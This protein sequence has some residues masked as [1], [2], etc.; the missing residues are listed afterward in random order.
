MAEG[1]PWWSG[2][3]NDSS[4]APAPDNSSP[5]WG[6]YGKAV[7]SGA[8]ELG[9]SI[10]AGIQ[11]Y[12][13]DETP[14]GR[15]VKEMG[16]V[17][18]R[19]LGDQAEDTSQSMTPVARQRLEA[20]ITSPEFWNHPLSSTALKATKMSPAA[21]AMI[22]PG[23]LIADATAATIATAGVGG[24]LN[25]AQLVDNV[26]KMVDQLPDD[27]LRAKSDYYN[28]LRDSN[29]SEEDARQ[30]LKSRLVTDAKPALNFAVGSVAAALGP[31]AAIVRGAKGAT[32]VIGAGERGALGRAAIGAGEA[33][34]GMGTQ[35]GVEE[36]SRQ[37]AAIQEG[38]Q[39]NFDTDK[40][41]EAVLEPTYLGAITGGAAGA[42]IKGKGVKTEP[43]PKVETET[44]TTSPAAE[45]RG[46]T[47]EKVGTSQVQKGTGTGNQPPPPDAKRPDVRYPKPSASDEEKIRSATLE[48]VLARTRQNKGAEVV[49]V[50]GPTS[51]QELALGKTERLAN[52]DVNPDVNP[53]L[54][55]RRDDVQ[56]PA[57]PPE[58]P[59]VTQEVTAAPRPAAPPAPEVRPE[60]VAPPKDVETPQAPRVLPALDQDTAQNVRATNQRIAA[61][62]KEAQP[63]EPKGKNRSKTDQEARAKSAA[64]AEALFV[65]SVPDEHVMPTTPAQ[66]G[67]LRDRLKAISDEADK[68]GIQVPTKVGYANTPDHI[69]W[70][71]EVKNLAKRMD[72]KSFVGK[73][74]AEHIGTFLAREKAAKAGDFSVMRNERKAE[75]DL[76]M[77]RDQ[78]EVENAAPSAGLVAESPE[79][80]IIRREEEEGR[81][82]PEAPRPAPKPRAPE[83][84]EKA[85]AR[86]KIEE[87]KKKAR[88]QA[89]AKEAEEKDRPWRRIQLTEEQKKAAIESLEKNMK[90]PPRP[91]PIADAMREV[92]TNPTPAQ[93]EAGNYAKGH[94]NVQGLKI[95]IENPRGSVRRGGAPGKEWETK[96]PDHY[97]YVKRTEGA[98]GDQVDVYVGRHPDS[99]RVYVVD[100]MDHRTGRFDEHK[101]M[102]GY[103][104][105]EEAESAYKRGFSDG[106]GAARMGAVTEMSVGDFKNWLR[107]GDTKN[108]VSE[109]APRAST[110]EDVGRLLDEEAERKQPPQPIRTTTT[111][112]I[113]KN[114]DLKHLADVPGA[115]QPFIA[116]RL[117]NLVGD[118]E[119]QVIS[120]DDMSKWRGPK[121][122]GLYT[123]DPETRKTIVYVREDQFANKRQLAHTMIHEATHA[124][125][126]H[127]L[128]MHPQQKELVRQM[129]GEVG[130]FLHH[131]VDAKRTLARDKFSYA[132]T[133]EREFIAEAF[134]NPDFQRFLS[135]IPTSRELSEKLSLDHRRSS[136][137][138]DAV[139][140]YVRRIVERVTGKIPGDVHNM[141]SAIMRHGE[142]L[143]NIEKNRQIR[144]GDIP[145]AYADRIEAPLTI[146]DAIEGGAEAV[147]RVASD[148]V[149]SI[150]QFADRP[151]AWRLLK[152]LG[153]K[154]L[155]NDQFRQRVEPVLPHARTVFD[156]VE[157]QGVYANKLKQEGNRLIADLM[158]LEKKL[159][160][161]FDKW[162]DL[163]NRQTAF[164]VDASSPLGIS[165]N[166]YLALSKTN[167]QRMAS[168]KY[169]PEDAP[170]AHWEAQAAHPGL[171]KEFNDLATQHPEF[172]EAQERLFRFFEEAQA[173]MTRGHIDQYLR[174]AGVDESTRVTESKRLLNANPTKELIEELENKYGDVVA[175]QI[176]DAKKLSG[177]EGVYAPLVRHGDYV[178]SGKYKVAEPTNAVNKVDEN[179]WEFRTRKE[180]YNFAQKTGLHYNVDTVYYDPNT[181]ERTTKMGGLSQTGSAEQRYEVNVQR[182]HVEFSESL[183]D[184][185][186]R[187]KELHESGVLEREPYVEEKQDYIGRDAEI[188][189]GALHTIMKKLE[190]TDEYRRA[191]NVQKQEMRK[192]LEEAA[193]VTQAGNRVQSRRLPRRRVE[194]ASDDLT[195]NMAIY[196]DSQSNYRAKVEFRPKVE[197]AI[198]DMQKYVED[199]RYSKEGALDPNALSR[200][201]A[202]NEVIARARALDPNEYSGTYTDWT[203]RLSTW[204][205]IDRMARPSH[206]LLHQTHLPMIT[207]PFISGRHGLAATYGVMLR[208]W[209]TAVRFYQA[210]G[211][212]FVKSIADGLH[213]GT[214][215]DKLVKESFKGEKD[216]GRLNK[217]FD[218]LAEI[219]L[220]HPQAG[221][222]VHKYAPSRQLKGAVGV[223]DK[224]I[225]KLDTVFRHAT[226]ATE[227]I[228]RYVGAAMAYRL[229]YAK[230]RKTMSEQKAHDGAVEYARQTLANTQGFY[231]STNAAPLFKNKWL[232][233]FLQFRQFPQMMYHLLISTAEK[234]FSG[235]DVR[236]RVQA[237]ASLATVLGTHTFMTGLLGGLPLEVGKIAG[238]VGKGLGITQNDWNDFER[239]QYEQAVKNLGK[240]G[241]EYIMHGAGRL[242][243]VD[244]HH[245]LGLNS[246]FTFGMPEKLTG[247]N[248]WA[249]LAKTAAGA[250]G[251]LVED[252]IKG[253][254]KMM[255]GN[256][257]DGAAQA[258]PL[259]VVRDV[260]RALEGG[261]QSG[262][263]YK[264]PGEVAARFL[265]FTPS[266]EA[267][268]YERK[269]EAYNLKQKYTDEK[270]A[271][272]KRWSD[273]KPD[274]KAQVWAAVQK[275][276]ADKPKDAQLTMADLQKSAHRREKNK[277]SSNRIYDINLDKR[278]KFI[279]DRA[280]A[281]YR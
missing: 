127:S 115:I 192:A 245:R 152:T 226:N 7:K 8:E 28:T 218:T 170:M 210:G 234:A 212:D 137:M 274:E 68:L 140:D 177:K 21:A 74:A 242:L 144:N 37:Q 172:R 161:A 150:K 276:N 156:L 266:G 120:K 256:I 73:R 180:A 148:P 27:Q 183:K 259:Q 189:A 53:D 188:G 181:G 238:L 35:T 270:N 154:L 67:E 203:R 50:V 6:D 248:V 33:G 58:Q 104:T 16:G 22:V 272:T 252:A 54:V 63:K 159:P 261:K 45:D 23:G 118:N 206:L 239:W 232:R 32:A 57:G 271:L 17:I 9:A 220:I 143:M 36:A 269:S 219:G 273:A 235:D 64:A 106:K 80:A 44:E 105:Q 204:S 158:G 209:K 201:E 131:P 134:S 108:P 43:K 96:V 111:G 24:A 48:D 89:E 260:K 243:G 186:A 151:D 155:T 59:D 196:N 97:G 42:V 91:E 165:R 258:F 233:P 178:V 251:G 164:G 157:K 149:E 147:K 46:V 109:S 71:R 153:H 241:A 25:V 19:N 100:Q 40:L 160:G 190:Q 69:V 124:A 113:L 168:G 90:R 197:E 93:K 275:W 77:R 215:Y 216:S 237:A 123:Y 99:D 122:L 263:E 30:Q 262:Y 83:T 114:L 119:V 208:T 250:P 244:V 107:E 84:P 65:R 281:I 56:P 179:T 2:L 224:T 214:D 98:D 138:W 200:S 34:A 213:E 185:Q 191:T 81:V 257:A 225:A 198:R 60:D 136:S 202:A 265:G 3:Y 15:L 92:E 133:S 221:L 139:V 10:G 264:S 51:E 169:S 173:D 101:A 277:E 171:A 55:E 229:E 141:M 78:G 167:Q 117:R 249:F 70:L 110:A 255:Q 163:V 132:M 240:E 12:A 38:L 211:N 267:E 175:K 39:Q 66:R 4:E 52:Q 47:D 1:D 103:R 18:R 94:I 228:N 125:T 31:S 146:R 20:S 102:L 26:Y 222:E 227:A 279:Q 231:S 194:G 29:V 116:R 236:T 253:F 205:Y 247:E 187:Q 193:L 112:E 49:D 280:E 142:T 254:Q 246:L 182:K 174:A 268:Y 195:R 76:A 87:I 62:V 11:E 14:E 121:D 230:L 207:A 41:V 5:T 13:S 176:L 135:L 95:S 82:A 88:A 79:D 61:N 129:M 223:M 130:E 184:A 128:E 85:S 166:E 162:S 199:N 126:V 72:Q 75:G 278:T 86:T 145:I 217:M